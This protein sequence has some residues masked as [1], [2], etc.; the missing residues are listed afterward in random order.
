MFMLSYPLTVFYT[1]T[2][3]PQTVKE[4]ISVPLCNLQ[5]KKNTDNLKQLEMSIMS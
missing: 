1:V 3:L 2:P 5:K 4:V